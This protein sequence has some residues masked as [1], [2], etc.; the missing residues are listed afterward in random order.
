MYNPN[1]NIKT[2]TLE[3]AQYQ[4]ARIT[5]V[6]ESY[7]QE[8][9]RLR[10]RWNQFKMH[11]ENLSILED[12][13]Q[14]ELESLEKIQKQIEKLNLTTVS[15]S[16]STKRI[17]FPYDIENTET[18]NRHINSFKMHCKDAIERNLLIQFSIQQT[19]DEI[20]DHIVKLNNLI[21][22]D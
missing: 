2:L 8:E 6:L 9:A 17:K 15:A 18:R 5:E 12:T 1:I 7:K 11:E 21:N 4:K 14:K 16:I 20:E 10:E 19:L 13:Y 22:L 3:G